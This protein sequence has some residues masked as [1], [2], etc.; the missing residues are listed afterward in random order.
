MIHKGKLTGDGRVPDQ[1]G[2]N[3]FLAKEQNTL[4]HLTTKIYGPGM[5]FEKLS[6][7]GQYT[8]ESLARQK[9]M[10]SDPD[11]ALRTAKSQIVDLSREIEIL[12]DKLAKALRDNQDLWEENEQLRLEVIDHGTEKNNTSRRT[13]IREEQS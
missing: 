4:D 6:V 2:L 7:L 12:N 10:I 8:I 5:K 3:E 9:A 13:R 11:P 1:V